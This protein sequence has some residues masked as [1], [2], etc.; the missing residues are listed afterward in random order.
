M[1]TCEPYRDALSAMLDG[2]NAPVGQEAVRRHLDVCDRCTAFAAASDD[3]ARRLRIATAEEVP[4]LTASILA[5]VDTPDAAR[6]RER[7]RQL[8]ALLALAGV[9]QLLLAVPSLVWAGAV[10][11]HVTREAGIFEVALAVGFLVVAWRPA[12]ASGLLPVAAVVALLAT[13]TSLAD[14]AMGTTSVV[15][16]SAH[17]LQVIGTG[18][19]WM[20]DRQRGRAPL[21][22]AAA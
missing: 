9:A 12:R 14:V 3:L 17:L 8:R 15:Q 19:L 13:V 2:E 21:H 4:D 16:E 18:L 6:V 7:F 20:L 11:G 5:A 1:S 22:L 10:A